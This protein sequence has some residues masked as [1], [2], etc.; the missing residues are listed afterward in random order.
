[1]S[2]SQILDVK[3]VFLTNHFRQLI[4]QKPNMS[5]NASLT[6]T[7]LSTQSAS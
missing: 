5:S 3:K 1:M 4:M 7:S 6:S 2:F